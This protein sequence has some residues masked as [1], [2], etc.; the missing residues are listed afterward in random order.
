MANS[1]I[2]S[3]ACAPA[4]V[5]YTKAAFHVGTTRSVGE[6]RDP[7]AENLVPLLAAERR[8]LAAQ[9]RRDDIAMVLHDLFCR[10][11][12]VELVDGKHEIVLGQQCLPRIGHHVIQTLGDAAARLL[13]LTFERFVFDQL[14][15]RVR[16]IGPGAM[17]LTGQTH[18]DDAVV[19]HLEA[20]SKIV[21][22]RDADADAF[23]LQRRFLIS[24]VG[25]YGRF[26]RKRRTDAAADGGRPRVQVDVFRDVEQVE[27]DDLP[28]QHVHGE[29]NTLVD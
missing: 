21:D 19:E 8:A 7:M 15:R 18:R 23:E 24:N 10:M 17:E 2:S 22:R 3:A 1:T 20:D 13:G 28:M 5:S 12:T 14:F 25:G 9:H 4:G 29:Q 27:R 16:K 6:V 26:R 11:R